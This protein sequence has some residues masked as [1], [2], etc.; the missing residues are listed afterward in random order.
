MAADITYRLLESIDDFEQVTDL[1]MAIWGS[2]ARDAIPANVLR[3][4]TLNGGFAVGAFVGARMIG[5]AVGFP[6][7][8]AG[9]VFLWSHI[10]GV[11]GDFQG[12][13]VGLA[14]KHQQ[15]DHARALGYNEIRWTFD[16]LQSRNAWFNITKL[17]AI[18]QCYYE[19]FYGVMDDAINQGLPS[20][21]IEAVWN[22]REPSAPFTPDMLHDLPA[23][24][25]RTDD[26]LPIPHALTG[27]R[28]YRVPVPRDLGALTLEQRLH[29]RLNLREALCAAFAAGYAIVYF[30]PVGVY[31]LLPLSK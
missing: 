31:A 7:L 12:L 17:G 8:R 6:A 14:L 5:M 25:T 21:R 19:N 28:G 30:D 10:A 9:S 13:G 24:M 22:L 29:W 1:E 11:H 4:M 27:A 26:G 18:S 23:L 16:P 2:G 3:P 20:D 15:R